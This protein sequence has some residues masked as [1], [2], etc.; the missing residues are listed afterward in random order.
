MRLYIAIQLSHEIKKQVKN[1]QEIFKREGVTGN[2]TPAANLHMTLAF[3]EE[4]NDHCTVLAAMKD[5]KL[6]PFTITM[7]KIG[8]FGVLWWL[9]IEENDELAALV[10]RL[11][12]QLKRAR[13]PYDRYKFRPYITFLNKARNADKDKLS[14]IIIQPTSMQV[15]RITLMQSISKNN[16]IIYTEI[17]SVSAQ[18]QP[19][20]IDI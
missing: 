13:I 9:G 16:G 20:Y 8:R 12:L 6:Y 5:A 10:L 7:N 18:P 19:P 14:S 1:V 15:K 3:L 11:R 4:F 2:Y 17:G